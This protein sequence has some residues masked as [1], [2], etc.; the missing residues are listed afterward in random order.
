MTWILNRNIRRPQTAAYICSLVLFKRPAGFH[1]RCSRKVSVYDILFFG[2]N[3][4]K[5][6]AM[7]F[8]VSCGW[9]PSW[10][11]TSAPWCCL[12]ISETTKHHQLYKCNSPLKV[13][14]LFDTWMKIVQTRKGTSSGF[15]Q[16]KLHRTLSSS[17]PNH[18]MLITP[19]GEQLVATERQILDIQKL[20]N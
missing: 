5:I 3:T 11:R 19:L 14:Q 8:L 1:F 6:C 18:N 20:R 4:I 15:D 10:Q 16:I 2:S 12:P 9:L 7:K 13:S 17:H